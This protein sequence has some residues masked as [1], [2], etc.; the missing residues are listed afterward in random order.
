M[1]KEKEK[2]KIMSEI[3]TLRDQLFDLSDDE[4]S[5][6]AKR[7]RVY[8]QEIGDRSREVFHKAKD[9]ASKADDWAHSNP[10][11]VAGSAILA[12]LLIGML[13]RRNKD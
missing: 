7:A 11:K 12:G 2:E 9:R 13:V 5:G 1:D 6:V 3:K 8:M 4:K 10:W